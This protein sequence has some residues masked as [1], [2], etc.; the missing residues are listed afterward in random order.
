M[1]RVVLDGGPA[2][3]LARSGA[4]VAHTGRVQFTG[5]TPPGRRNRPTWPPPS[6]T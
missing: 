2:D 5:W 4:M 3:V 6:W 1:L